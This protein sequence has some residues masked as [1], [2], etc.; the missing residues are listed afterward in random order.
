MSTP[1][2]SLSPSLLPYPGN[3]NIFFPL[4]HEDFFSFL[5][6]FPNP[7]AKIPIS[8]QDPPLI[9]MM[10]IF[11]FRFRPHEQTPKKE[12]YLNHD[13]VN[14][15]LLHFS[16]SRS[17]FFP[18]LSQPNS[19]EYD[20]FFHYGNT[21]MKCKNKRKRRKKI[22]RKTLC[23]YS[24]VQLTYPLDHRK[25]DGSYFSIPHFPSLSK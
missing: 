10:K 17:F 18:S 12:A 21:I 14:S 11:V 15:L 20:F 25:T 4:L 24:P 6:L 1:H 5:P 7:F 3:D 16:S 13:I 9:T 23:I 2:V 22:K 19:E 8:S